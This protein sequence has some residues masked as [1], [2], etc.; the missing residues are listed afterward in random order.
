MRTV[1]IAVTVIA[2]LVAAYA[3]RGSPVAV[4]VPGGPDAVAVAEPG[5]DWPAILSIIA[6][7]LTAIEVAIRTI[8]QLLAKRKTQE[9]PDA[10]TTTPATPKPPDG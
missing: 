3:L 2:L 9:A 10:A 7:A 1:A 5:I 6:G 4:K 8:L